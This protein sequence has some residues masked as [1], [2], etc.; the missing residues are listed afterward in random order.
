LFPD[1]KRPAGKYQPEY[2]INALADTPYTD[3]WQCIWETS[4]DGLTG[5]VHHHPLDSW[6]KFSGKVCVELDIDR[7]DITF[8]GTSSQIDGLIR[9]EVEKIGSKRGGLMMVYGLYPGIPLKNV[10]A[11]MD[12]MERYS[13]FYS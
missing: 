13:L 6:D 9:E 5:S 12:A 11:V 7:Q 8:A 3:P 1:F 2:L 4:E 10:S